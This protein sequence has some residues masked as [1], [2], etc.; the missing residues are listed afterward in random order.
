VPLSVSVDLV[1][2]SRERKRD[3]FKDGKNC[4]AHGCAV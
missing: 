1:V 2:S 4:E 3:G